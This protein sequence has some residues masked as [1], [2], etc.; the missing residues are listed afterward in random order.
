MLR[1]LR[2]AYHLLT[3]ARGCN[4]CPSAHFHTIAGDSA[5]PAKPS[6]SYHFPV[7]PGIRGLNISQRVNP[8]FS[9]KLA[10]RSR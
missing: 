10:A 8:T 2:R 4:R 7:F 1:V 5:G 9:Y 3:I 6:I